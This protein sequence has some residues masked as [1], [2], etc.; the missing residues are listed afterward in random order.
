MIPCGVPQGSILG[1]QLFF[2][3]Y[4]NDEPDFSPF[5]AVYLLQLSCFTIPKYL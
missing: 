4:F 1:P 5:P 2:L 3:L